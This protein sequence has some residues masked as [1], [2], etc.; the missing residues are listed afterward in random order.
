[1]TRCQRPRTA[2]PTTTG[3]RQAD[4]SNRG[5][6]SAPGLVVSGCWEQGQTWGGA[7]TAV[8]AKVRRRWAAAIR[9]FPVF[10]FCEWRPKNTVAAA[11]VEDGG[12][13]GA[14]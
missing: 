12:E 9:L 1:V 10:P 7:L 2:R 4:P 13:R 5:G 3:R 8:A 6:G 14:R 11:G